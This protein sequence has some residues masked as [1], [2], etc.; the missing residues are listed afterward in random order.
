M[1]AVALEGPLWFEEEKTCFLPLVTDTA[2]RVL[3]S[4][5]PEHTYS[6][7]QPGLEED[8]SANDQQQQ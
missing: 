3:P 8:A 7:C 5:S 1:R 6:A 2:T 4:T